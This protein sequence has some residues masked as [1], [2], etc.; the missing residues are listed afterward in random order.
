MALEKRTPPPLE[1]VC[2]FNWQL[3]NLGVKEGGG[4]RGASKAEERLAEGLI[5]QDEERN[6]RGPEE[7]SPSQ[8]LL[9][10]AE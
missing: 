4:A 8:Q 6:T 3:E 7:T 5:W 9:D 1:S 2:F 10:R